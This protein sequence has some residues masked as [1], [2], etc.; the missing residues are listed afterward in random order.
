MRS[1]SHRSPARPPGEGDGNGLFRTPVVTGR[2]VGFGK[3]AM[4]V[5]VGGLYGRGG[6]VAGD[7]RGVGGGDG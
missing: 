2:R 3:G 4:A 7:G 1:E 6:G 5:I